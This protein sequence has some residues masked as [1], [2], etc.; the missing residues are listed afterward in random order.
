M[1]RRTPRSTLPYTLFPY[2]PL[3]LSGPYCPARV[4][5]PLD[6][7]SWNRKLQTN[8]VVTAE[9]LF[10]RGGTIRAEVQP[11]L[12]EEFWAVGEA[13]AQPVLDRLASSGSP[14]FVKV[15]VSHAILGILS[16]EGGGERRRDRK[17]TRLNS[18]H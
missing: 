10:G 17:S 16:P 5:F 14:R 13:A 15:A 8:F 4:G 6:V 9:S 1:R 11:G 3:F 12:P 2:P 7:S 18:S